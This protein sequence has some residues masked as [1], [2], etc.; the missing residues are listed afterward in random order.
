MKKI[1]PSSESHA[2]NEGW[3]SNYSEFLFFKLTRSQF[4]MKG[5]KNVVEAKITLTQDRGMICYCGGSQDCRYGKY[6]EDA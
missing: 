1:A 4:K 6:N 5:T 3:F 2:A